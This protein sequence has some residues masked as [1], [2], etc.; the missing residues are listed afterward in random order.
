MK[1]HELWESYPLQEFIASLLAQPERL[2]SFQETPEAF[3]QAELESEI[4]TLLTES[5][6]SDTTIKLATFR[7]ALK[8]S[9]KKKW[10]SY[11]KKIKMNLDLQLIRNNPQ[12]ENKN[13]KEYLD[14]QKK[15]KQFIS[16][17]DEE[18]G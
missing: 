3:V 5:L 7:E 2:Q 14:V 12:A 11:A 6:V 15:M 13:L 9:L 8:Y 1:L 4:Q 16:F 17:Y 18:S 10:L